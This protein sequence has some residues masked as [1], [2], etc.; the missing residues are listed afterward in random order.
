MLEDGRSQGD[1]ARCIVHSTA[2]CSKCAKKPALTYADQEQ[3]GPGLRSHRKIDTCSRQ[4]SEIGF[5]WKLQWYI[6]FY[7]LE[8]ITYINV[9]TVRRRL[10]EDGLKPQQIVLNWKM[11]IVLQDTNISKRAQFR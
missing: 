3:A 11:G 7:I 8:G 6:N 9:W 2:G 10:A 1:T 5:L 4:F